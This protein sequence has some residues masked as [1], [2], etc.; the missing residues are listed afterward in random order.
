MLDIIR[1]LLPSFQVQRFA[2]ADSATFVRPP[3]LRGMSADKILVLVNGK[4]R[5][6]SALVQLSGE[7]V[8]G[9][10]L[11][12][13][14]SIALKSVEVLRDGASALYGSDA[15]AGVFNF[16]LSDWDVFRIENGNP[17]YR[18]NFTGMH[19][20]ANGVSATLRGNWYGDYD[21]ANMDE[22]TDTQNMSG[23]VYWDID[24]TWDVSDTLSVTLGGDNVFDASPDS[25][26]NFFFPI[27]APTEP[28]TVLDW[29]GPYY[30]ARA[31]LRWN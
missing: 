27:G 18:V 6:R 2:I 4:R 16:N 1:T 5:H 8:H 19:H 21:V 20:W 7:G 26:P 9:P 29:E 23:D 10:D 30:Y 11:A 31:I 14:P 3:Q 25:A 15:I 24:L 17:D 13:I 28:D 22:V 12:T